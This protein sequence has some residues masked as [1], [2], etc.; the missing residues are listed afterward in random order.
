[1]AERRVGGQKWLADLISPTSTELAIDGR[2]VGSERGVHERTAS[3]PPV[4]KAAH[5]EVKDVDG[6]RSRP[7]RVCLD[8]PVYFMGRAIV[9]FPPTEWEEVC[10]MQGQ[11]RS[12]KRGRERCFPL[13]PNHTSPSL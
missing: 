6:K 9:G 7:P 2:S 11:L 3:G 10:D 13:Y 5:A 1:M 4:K 12:K 8:L